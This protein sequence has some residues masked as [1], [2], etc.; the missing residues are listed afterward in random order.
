M[1]GHIFPAILAAALA[2]AQAEIKNPVKN[3]EVTVTPR[4]GRPYSFSYATLDSILDGVRP[5]LAKHGLSIVQTIMQEGE[6]PAVVRTHLVHKSGEV[7]SGDIRLQ[8]DKAGNQGLGSAMTYARRYGLLGLLA[9]SA[10]DDNDANEADGNTVTSVGKPGQAAATGTQP[11]RQPAGTPR[12]EPPHVARAKVALKGANAASVRQLH[13][14]MSL[15][16]WTAVA[17]LSG[18]QL[19]TYVKTLGDIEA[20]K[21]VNL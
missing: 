13:Q 10:D 5:I 8:I 21:E 9:L 4:E 12:G 2:D 11:T 19:S 14:T 17:N 3:R 7:I 16:D 1:T 18:E 20:G 6:A 15:P